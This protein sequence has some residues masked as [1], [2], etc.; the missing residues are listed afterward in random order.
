MGYE[1]DCETDGVPSYIESYIYHAYDKTAKIIYTF[2]DGEWFRE[3]SCYME[4]MLSNM[5]QLDISAVAYS[6]DAMQE[7]WEKALIRA[8]SNTELS[9]YEKQEE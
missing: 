3:R 5:K 8:V 7:V 4:S 2:K 1:F 9:R 6:V